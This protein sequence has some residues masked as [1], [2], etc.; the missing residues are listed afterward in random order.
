MCLETAFISEECSMPF[1]VKVAD[2]AELQ[3]RIYGKGILSKIHS[4]VMLHVADCVSGGDNSNWLGKRKKQTINPSL[5]DFGMYTF[6]S[7]KPGSRH[8][9]L[10]KGHTFMDNVT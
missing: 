10:D 4:G 6:I 5:A 3:G 1:V 8:V 7:R 9:Q 2:V